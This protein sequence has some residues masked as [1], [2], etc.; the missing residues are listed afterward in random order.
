MSGTLIYQ[1][2]NFVQPVDS[3]TLITNAVVLDQNGP[4]YK[5]KMWW[6]PTALQWILDLEDSSGKGIVRGC[7]VRDRTDCLLGVS[8]PGRPKGAITAYDNKHRGDPGRNAFF[9]EGVLLLYVPA[10]LD[11]YMFSKYDTPVG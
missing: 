7:W 6:L 5:I 2:L 8:T 3:D 11:P 9:N 1:Q 4:T 10:G